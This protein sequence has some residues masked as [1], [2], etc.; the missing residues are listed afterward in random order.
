MSPLDPARIA[1]EVAGWG[2]LLRP[3][4]S[5]ALCAALQDAYRTAPCHPAPSLWFDAFRAVGTPDDVRV[6]I[7][8]QDPYHGPGQANGLAFSVSKGMPIP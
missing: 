2:S 7:L 4:M 1:E 8:G 6:C 3:G 5:D